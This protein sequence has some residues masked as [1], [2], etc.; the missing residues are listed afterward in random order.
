MNESQSTDDIEMD[1]IVHA[2]EAA[3]H[4]EVPDDFAARLMARLPAQPLTPPRRRF[5]P[6]QPWHAQVRVGRTFTAVALVVLL[7]G[8]LL[9]APRTTGSVEWL[10]LQSLLFAQ[11]AA[12]LLWLGWSY[13]QLR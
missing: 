10:L 11:F 4:V 12:L 9:A 13:K 6:E 8:M 7:A 1:P 3:P 2:L 5:V